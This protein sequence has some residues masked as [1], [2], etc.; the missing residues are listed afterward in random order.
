[1]KPT[2]KTSRAV[3]LTGA[4][5]SK[6]PWGRLATEICIQV[7][8]H[9]A[10]AG[11]PNVRELLKNN[12]ND[13]EL[14]LDETRK[15]SPASACALEKA[16]VAAFIGM[17]DTMRRAG[18]KP[19]GSKYWSHLIQA[20]M[21]MGWDKSIDTG[22]FFTTNQDL[23]VERTYFNGSRPRCDLILPGD[24]RPAKWQLGTSQPWFAS[25]QGSTLHELMVELDPTIQ[26]SFVGRFNYVKLHGSANWRSITGDGMLIMGGSKPVQIAAF[27]ILQQFH[28]QFRSVLHAGTF[29]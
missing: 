28:N 19:V 11:H 23:L 2:G 3:L 22:F 20:F 1:M 27:P 12:P 14:A 10:L 17:D 4:G 5:F 29:A 6:D 9:P 21:G 16:I 26:S 8:G 25:P 24:P 7:F 13:Y 15:Q 18:P